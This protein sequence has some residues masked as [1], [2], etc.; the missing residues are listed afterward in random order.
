MLTSAD[1]RVLLTVKETAARLGLHP[2]TVRRKIE[3][4]EIPAVRLG[5]K[6]ASIRIDE[7]ELEAWLYG[8][9]DVA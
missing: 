1:R 6:G 4:G 7:A 5:H 3:R 8:P 2:M 9:G